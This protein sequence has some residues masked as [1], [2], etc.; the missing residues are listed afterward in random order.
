MTKVQI[1]RKN[2]KI[3][4]FLCDGHTDY[5]EEGE[6]II[7]S[8]LSSITQTAVLGLMQVAFL[9]IDYK[10]DNKNA[11]LQVALPTNMTDIERNNADMILET[12]FLGITDLTT[13]YGRYIQ[14][15]NLK[16]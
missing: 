4:G 6:D 1:T 9:P 5:G 16:E 2:N 11:L 13:E 8:A 15:E 3:V 10:I 7:C 14:L 12:M